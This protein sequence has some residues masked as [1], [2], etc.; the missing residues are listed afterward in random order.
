MTGR[1]YSF[2]GK[3]YSLTELFEVLSGQTDFSVQELEHRWY[4]LK[5]DFSNHL[6]DENYEREYKETIKQRKTGNYNGVPKINLDSSGHVKFSESL[7]LFMRSNKCESYC[8]T[9]K[10]NTDKLKSMSKEDLLKASFE[11]TDRYTVLVAGLEVC[12]RDLSHLIYYKFECGSRV[13]ISH[14]V[15]FCSWGTVRDFVDL[16]WKF[17][18]EKDPDKLP[19]H[20]PRKNSNNPSYNFG[21]ST[22]KNMNCAIYLL[23]KKNNLPSYKVRLIL[24][25][26]FLNKLISRNSNILAKDEL[27]EAKNKLA[28]LD[29]LYKDTNFSNYESLMGHSYHGKRE[30][31]EA[32]AEE[33]DTTIEAVE[34]PWLLASVG[35]EVDWE[36]F[37]SEL[38]TREYRMG[39]SNTKYKNYKVD[40]LR[41]FALKD[42][43]Q[44][45]SRICG[46]TN[47]EL[48]K[49]YRK[50]GLDEINKGLKG[51]KRNKDEHYINNTSA[52]L[53]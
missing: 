35:Y 41:F 37:E 24:Q 28:Y 26:K 38:T 1:K 14:C 50:G 6:L 25:R 32:L 49:L 51:V 27:E 9:S 42:L 23:S 46:L 2:Q 53:V 52:Q 12:L 8:P 44:Q 18:D 36:L 4:V 19:F 15:S 21:G 20:L 48:E 31:L 11:V 10:I 33:Y 16:S 45:F 7:N 40:G 47:K 17:I 43:Y 13:L 5:L 3:K 30:F 34:V 29:K 22:F 39:K